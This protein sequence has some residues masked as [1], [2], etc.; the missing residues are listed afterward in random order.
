M[1]FILLQSIIDNPEIFYRHVDNHA[2]NFPEGNNL[3][4]GARCEW[5]GNTCIF[6]SVR[7]CHHFVSIFLI[8]VFFH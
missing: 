2:E 7:Y 1:M 5:E 8:F 4:G 3:E 6:S